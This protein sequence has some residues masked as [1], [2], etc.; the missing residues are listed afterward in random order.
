MGYIASEV[1][2]EF[3]RANLPAY[4]ISDITAVILLSAL[5]IQGVKSRT[6]GLDVPRG[7]PRYV[8][9]SCAHAHPKMSAISLYVS[10]GVFKGISVDL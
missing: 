2:R 10:S 6:V 7:R 8:N 1:T 5:Q 4:Y 9:G 3:M